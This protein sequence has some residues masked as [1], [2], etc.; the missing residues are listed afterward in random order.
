[1]R[2]VLRSTNLP[3]DKNVFIYYAIGKEF[4]DLEEWEEAFRYFKM[5]GDA[6]ASV[7]NYDV[8]HR[9]AVDRQDHRCL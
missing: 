3:P 2:E 6:V 8:N 5:G 9:L 1:M 4:E 7:A